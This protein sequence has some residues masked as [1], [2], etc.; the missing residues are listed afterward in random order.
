MCNTTT[1]PEA[2]WVV[3][4][5]RLSSVLDD[6]PRSDE[7]GGFVSPDELLGDDLQYYHID[8]I[9]AVAYDDTSRLNVNA[10]FETSTRARLKTARTLLDRSNPDG[11]DQ[12]R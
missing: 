11:E 1:N 10:E 9:C 5:I 6:S 4:A 3:L 2:E 8:E 7:P 12:K